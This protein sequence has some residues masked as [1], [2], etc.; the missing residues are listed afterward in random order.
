MACDRDSADACLDYTWTEDVAFSVD[1]TIERIIE[2]VAENPDILVVWA[3][4]AQAMRPALDRAAAADI[5]IVAINVPD[6]SPSVERVPYLIYIGSDESQGGV[7]AADQILA[8]MTPARAACI[9]K[10][11]DHAAVNIRCAGWTETMTAAGVPVDM[12]DVNGGPAKG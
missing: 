2:A 10:L 12:V 11:P 9:N 1:T 6:L 8:K 4:D 5:P 3:V 7:A